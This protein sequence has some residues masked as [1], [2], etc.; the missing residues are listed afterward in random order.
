MGK[1]LCSKRVV[2]ILRQATVNY[3]C[4]EVH[5]GFVMLF[6]CHVIGVI[7]IFQNELLVLYMQTSME[8]TQG[9]V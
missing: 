9:L 2:F 5:L 6:L 7:T 8:R 3:T 1:D 4:T